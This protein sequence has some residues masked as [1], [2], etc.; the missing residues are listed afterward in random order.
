MK[1]LLK[2]NLFLYLKNQKIIVSTCVF[3]FLYIIVELRLKV[4]VDRSVDVSTWYIYDLLSGFKL[5]N[6]FILI[7]FPFLFLYYLNIDSKPNLN[8]RLNQLPY[9][10]TTSIYSKLFIYLVILVL[11]MICFL[12]ILEWKFYL[13][14]SFVDRSL[15]LSNALIYCVF[16]IPYMYLIISLFYYFRNFTVLL[17]THFF[18]AL[19]SFF[20]SFFWLPNSWGFLVVNGN[21]YL[22]LGNRLTFY[23][24]HPIQYF[25]YYFMVSLIAIAF[26][27]QI[28]TNKRV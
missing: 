15:I 21:L 17:I 20:N 27:N 16:T 8:D 10:K 13:N 9:H 23:Q 2:F 11:L 5:F 19:F 12:S 24:D 4:F 26:F 22:E 1:N 14:K 3:F 6:F 7:I 25:Y 28:F 18:L